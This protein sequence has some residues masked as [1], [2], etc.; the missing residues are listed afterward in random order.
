MGYMR[1]TF[2]QGKKTAISKL[3]ELRRPKTC[4]IP[5]F[6]FDVALFMRGYIAAV[7]SGNSVPS[8]SEFFGGLRA[9]GLSLEPQKLPLTL[10]VIGHL[11]R[12][13]TDN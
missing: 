11:E 13:P 4:S 3:L 8:D 6:D 2:A 10:L 12:T 7:I 5:F 9:L 1:P